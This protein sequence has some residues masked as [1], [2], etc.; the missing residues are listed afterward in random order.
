MRVSFLIC[1]ML[2][3]CL[4]AHGQEFKTKKFTG[5]FFTEVFQVEKK[6]KQKHGTYLKIQN[7]NKD[8]IIRGQYLNDS[9]IGVWTYFDAKNQPYMK[10]DYSIDSCLW[11]SELV[12]KPDTFPIRISNDFE[13][14]KLNRPPLYI[15]F[16]KE[17]EISF[18]NSIRIPLDVMENGKS[19]LFIASFVINT[20]GEI[21]EVN[22]DEI[23]NPQIRSAVKMTFQ[24]NKWKY[25]PGL[26]DGKPVDTKLFLA[27]DIGPAGHK[28]KIP[29]KAYVTKIDIQ[30]FGIKRVVTKTVVSTSSPNSFRNNMSGSM[31]N[32]K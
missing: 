16:S 23:E 18:I 32:R 21:I 14:A 1:I 8:T 3:V 9:M 19:L 30:Y 6:S 15:G 11:I 13:F 29:T 7:L 12:N 4:L 2:S 24:K 26:L 28:Q 20:A 22:T 17:P 27:F 25:L 5:Q 10:Y 31:I